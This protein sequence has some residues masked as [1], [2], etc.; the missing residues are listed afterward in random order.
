M[1][2]DRALPYMLTAEGWDSSGDT[3][4]AYDQRATLCALPAPRLWD[5]PE[6]GVPTCPECRKVL[7]AVGN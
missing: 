1:E 3:H 2:N 4:A 6:Q 5:G 7:A